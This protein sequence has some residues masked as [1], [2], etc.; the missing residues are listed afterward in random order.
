MASE[1]PPELSIPPPI[2]VYNWSVFGLD[3]ANVG[4]A[5]VPESTFETQEADPIAVNLEGELQSYQNDPFSVSDDGQDDRAVDTERVEELEKEIA[6]LKEEHKDINEVTDRLEAL[7]RGG[8]PH[9]AVQMKSL[10]KRKLLLKDRIS[11]LQQELEGLLSTEETTQDSE[12]YSSSEEGSEDEGEERALA[13]MMAVLADKG[14][15]PDSVPPHKDSFFLA[16]MKA[17]QRAGLRPRG[18]D[19]RE[20]EVQGS[21]R[22]YPY[23]A[24]RAKHE[25]LGLLAAQAHKLNRIGGWQLSP[26]EFKRYFSK[27]WWTVPAARHD[28]L[29]ASAH[30]FSVRI[31]ALALTPQGLEQDVYDPPGGAPRATLHL[32]RRADH[33]ISS[34]PRDASTSSR[35]AFAP[36]PPEEVN[37]SQPAEALR[38]LPP[39]R[40]QPARDMFSAEEEEAEESEDGLMAGL[41]LLER[42]EER[43]VGKEC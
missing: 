32:C 42:S 4:T 11:A 20:A 23:A 29:M 6:M 38:S 43:R 24:K 36:P 37:A 33:V 19:F 35:V 7:G 18:Y 10:K 22:Q 2:P 13:E 31:I 27:A 9:V 14:L 5:Y 15:R 28:L 34:L 26:A 40:V 25:V 8:S 41:G 21:G 39:P 3:A 1:I 17:L 12:E 16:L 30:L